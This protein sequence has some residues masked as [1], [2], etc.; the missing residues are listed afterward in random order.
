MDLWSVTLNQ[1]TYLF[2]Q[3]K[4]DRSSYSSG[5]LTSRII[6]VTLVT[7]SIHFAGLANET[8][9]VN[10]SITGDTLVEANETFK[11]TLGAVSNTSAKQKASIIT[12]AFATG[13][14]INDD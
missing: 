14:I 3:L 2:R 4:G 11:V 12:G 6:L 8:Q 10:V 9:P 5:T 1:H 7:K 13:T